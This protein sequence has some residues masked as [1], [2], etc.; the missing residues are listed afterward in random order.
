MNILFKCAS[1]LT[2]FQKFI[3]LENVLLWKRS[4]GTWDQLRPSASGL[5]IH[6]QT[7]VTATSLLSTKLNVLCRFAG[8]KYIYI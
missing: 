2:V 5:E 7:D 8:V 4:A 1:Q 6:V 3:M